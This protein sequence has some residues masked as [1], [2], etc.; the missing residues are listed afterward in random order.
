MFEDLA[1]ETRSLLLGRV[2]TLLSN[3][4]VR[5]LSRSELI[6]FGQLFVS[7]EILDVLTEIRDLLKEERKDKV[8]PRSTASGAT[9]GGGEHKEKQNRLSPSTD[10]RFPEDLGWRVDKEVTM[11]AS[12][13]SEDKDTATR[14]K[15]ELSQKVAEAVKQKLDFQAETIVTPVDKESSKSNESKTGSSNGN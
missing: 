2:D 4:E 3:D 11:V 5:G 12:S 13:S 1:D 14:N 6:G 15:E 10:E 9:N 7:R 8:S